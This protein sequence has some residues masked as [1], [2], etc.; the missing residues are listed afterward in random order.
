MVRKLNCG[1]IQLL[2][3]KSTIPKR[4]G[5]I[6][7]AGDQVLYETMKSHS[8]ENILPPHKDKF[9][10][11]LKHD[12][13]NLVDL[14]TSDDG[15]DV[16]GNENLGDASKANFDF[17]MTETPSFAQCERVGE[18]MTEI[19]ESLPYFFEFIYKPAGSISTIPPNFST[20]NVS[21]H[22]NGTTISAPPSKRVHLF[23]G[24]DTR[25]LGFHHQLSSNTGY[26]QDPDESYLKEQFREYSSGVTFP[27]ASKLGTGVQDKKSGTQVQHRP[28]ISP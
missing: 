5:N 20:L 14:D 1:P 18:F 22:S 17:S 12:E 7:N 24:S 8:V 23:F 26:R 9:R 13:F 11:R 19:P 15:D 3:F 6:K 21:L 28:L 27:S 4:S 2:D 25:M 16:D 10:A